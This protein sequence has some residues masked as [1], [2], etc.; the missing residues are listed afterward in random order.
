MYIPKFFFLLKI[1]SFR[2]WTLF[3]WAQ[4]P[5]YTQWA[6][7]FCAC[8]C[9]YY[10]FSTKPCSSPLLTSPLLPSLVKWATGE[11][12]TS[13]NLAA[14]ASSWVERENER[15]TERET[16]QILLMETAKHREKRLVL[17]VKCAFS[18]NTHFAVYHK[19]CALCVLFPPSHSSPGAPLF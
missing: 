1:G 19:T 16:E 2:R 3:A 15:E 10:L 9:S 17:R 4:Q 11:H 18:V 14:G 13:H 5:D 7:F 6:G 8:K 12:Q